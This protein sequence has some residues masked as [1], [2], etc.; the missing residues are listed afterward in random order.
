MNHLTNLLREAYKE[1]QI[2]VIGGRI[3]YEV[4]LQQFIDGH[5]HIRSFGIRIRNNHRKALGLVRI[6]LEKRTDLVAKFFTLEVLSDRDIEKLI[7]SL[8]HDEKTAFQSISTR[9]ATKTIASPP[10]LCCRLTESDMVLLADC[11]NAAHLFNS[12]KITAEMMYDLMN[13][14]LAAPLVADN[15]PG[16]VYLFDELSKLKVITGRWQSALE[17]DAS[18]LQQSTGK[19]QKATNLSSAL[20]RTRANPVFEHRKEIDALISYFRLKYPKR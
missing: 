20:N 16:I 6:L 1:Y 14:R 11:A 17:H 13:D 18:I 7:E 19:P 9:S 2:N 5:H 3:S 15:L 10:T 8:Y 12:D 4:F